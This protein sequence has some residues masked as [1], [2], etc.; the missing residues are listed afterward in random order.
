MQ[1]KNEDIA[2]SVIIEN[3]IVLTCLKGVRLFLSF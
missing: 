3:G 1:R 2:I